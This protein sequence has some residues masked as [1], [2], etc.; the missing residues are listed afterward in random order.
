MESRFTAQYEDKIFP[1]VTGHDVAYDVMPTMEKKEHYK[2][3]GSEEE[4]K[5][6]YRHCVFEPKP[7]EVFCF[8]LAARNKKLTEAERQEYKLGRAE[9]LNTNIVSLRQD[10]KLTY[11]KWREGVLRFEVNK[12]AITTKSGLSYPDKA[13]VVY[14]YFH[15]SDEVKVLAEG[16]KY[17]SDI[18]QELINAAVKGS[19]EGVNMSLKKLKYAMVNVE[20]MHARCPGTKK[21]VDFD[22]DIEPAYIDKF[23]Y[24]VIL[25]NLA[26]RLDEYF[27]IK[28]YFIIDTSGGFHILVKKEAIKGS[29]IKFTSDVCKDVELEVSNYDK[30][31]NESGY[32]VPVIKEFNINKNNLIPLPGTFQYGRL[33]KVINKGDFKDEDR[34]MDN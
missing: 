2:F 27:G 14:Y 26:D 28:N 13:T 9:M 24:N 31:I 23:K 17:I 18:N 11:R 5:W 19:Q 34:E 4:L 16:A 15:T 32:T 20:R 3:L 21:F 1:N 12:K 10:E 8:A 7:N 29:P 6:F 33:V 30:V 22:M 25:N